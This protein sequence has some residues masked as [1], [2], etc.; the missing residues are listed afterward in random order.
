MGKFK[1]AIK[2]LFFATTIWAIGEAM[3]LYF[4]IWLPWL[5][6]IGVKRHTRY[7]GLKVLF[8]TEKIISGAKR[9]I[10]TQ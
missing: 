7:P 10:I 4:L 8:G 1:K 2:D 5:P 9:S 6:W 3:L